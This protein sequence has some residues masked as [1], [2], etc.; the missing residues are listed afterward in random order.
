MERAEFQRGDLV[1]FDW[2]GEQMLA[3]VLEAP[4]GRCMLSAP[5]FADYFQ[6]PNAELRRLSAWGVLWF[7]A[8]RWF[9]GAR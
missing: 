3:T 5:G 8:K 7:T 1:L 9:N 6:I 2:H 4:P